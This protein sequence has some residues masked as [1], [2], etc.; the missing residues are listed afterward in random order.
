MKNLLLICFQIVSL[1]C[2]GQCID[3][4]NNGINTCYKNYFQQQPENRGLYLLQEVKS[5][6]ELSPKYFANI[7][8]DLHSLSGLSKFTAYEIDGF[9]SKLILSDTL[10]LEKYLDQYKKQITLKGILYKSNTANLVFDKNISI[11]YY[12]NS[13]LKI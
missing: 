3:D 5:K 2:M 9:I 1:T 4:W 7:L 13:S 12:I 6:K 10:A 8:E 11:E